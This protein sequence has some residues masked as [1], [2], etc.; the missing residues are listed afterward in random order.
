[1]KIV[2]KYMGIFPLIYLLL[3]DMIGITKHV[4]S[5]VKRLKYVL[6]KKNIDKLI[7]EFLFISIRIPHMEHIA[8]CK[9]VFPFM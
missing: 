1:M 2:V 4:S 3:S 5:V 7:V 6:Y 8:H 9:M